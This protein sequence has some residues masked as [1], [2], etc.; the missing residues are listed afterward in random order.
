MT[1]LE[2]VIRGLECCTAIQPPED[3]EFQEYWGDCN[4]CPIPS[5]EYKEQGIAACKEFADASALIPVALI[6]RAIA[7]LK[8][9]DP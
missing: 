9:I 6:K 7:L 5:A 2:L 3:S 8:E 1:E 4:N